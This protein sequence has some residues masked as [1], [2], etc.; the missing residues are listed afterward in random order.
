M[1][2]MDDFNPAGDNPVPPPLPPVPLRA[3]LRRIGR[4]GLRVTFRTAA[5][6]AV[7][8]LFG[9]LLRSSFRAHE[10]NAALWA[11]SEALADACRRLEER[12]ASLA[13]ESLA[14]EQDPYYI[15]KRIRMDWRQMK[16]GELILERSSR[17]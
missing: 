8:V 10:R 4:K 11:R 1:T 14:L 12:R 16:D 15:E 3:R 13:K 2:D 5:A 6:V 7:A 9:L 17:P